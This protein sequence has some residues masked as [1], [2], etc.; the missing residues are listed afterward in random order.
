MTQSILPFASRALAAACVAT[1]LIAGTIQA[2][3]VAKTTG[4]AKSAPAVMVDRLAQQSDVVAV[5]RVSGVRSEWNE[6]KSRIQTR[7]TLAVE[8]GIKGAAA[9][10]SITILTPGGEVEGVGELYTHMPQF[11]ENEEVLVFASKDAKGNL[12]VTSGASGK[13]TVEKDAATGAK[14]V[15][16]LGTIDELSAKIRK[17]QSTEPKRN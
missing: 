7:V 15:Q 3:S 13:F 11:K 5:A 10:E 1:L 17:A 8:Q 12:R 14:R 2:Q 4:R 9:E 16:N 6:D